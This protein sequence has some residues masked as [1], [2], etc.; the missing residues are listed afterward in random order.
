MKIMIIGYSGSGKSTLAEKLS[1]ETDTPVLHLDSVNWLPGW[2]IREQ[3]SQVGIV[4]SFMDTH[5]SWIIEGNYTK[6]LNERRLQEAD[7]I[8]ELLFGRINCYLRV[9]RRLRTYKGTSRP[10]MTEGCNEKIDWEFTRWIF[11]DGRNRKKRQLYQS[12]Q[13]NY[14]DKTIVIRNQRQLDKFQIPPSISES[15]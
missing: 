7:L 5:G 2:Q 14:P 10:D 3:K 9:L 4:N 6:I 1:K 8:L 11:Y 13:N 12:Y 15:R